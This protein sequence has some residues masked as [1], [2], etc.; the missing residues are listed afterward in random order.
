MGESLCKYIEK[1][2]LKINPLFDFLEEFLNSEKINMLLTINEDNLF[3][4]EMY[5][6][7]FLC[8]KKYYN[9][10]INKNG[11]VN[12][13]EL[14]TIIYLLKK[15]IYKTKVNNILNLFIFDENDLLTNQDNFYFIKET[16]ISC[17]KKLFI[18]EDEDFDSDEDIKLFFNKEIESYYLTIFKALDIQDVKVSSL[19]RIIEHDEAL[20]NLLYKINEQCEELFENY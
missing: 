8:D 18:I 4:E 2:N 5:C 17:I 14:M 10:L 3:D 7:F 15:D 19:K 12:F 20:Y 11:Y 9:L 1:N 6:S 13:W 16:F